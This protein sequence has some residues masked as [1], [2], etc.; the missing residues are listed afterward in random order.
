[1]TVPGVDG[2]KMSKSYN[3]Y[4][5]IFQTDKKLRKNVMKIVTD[6]TPME[7]P[8]DPDNCNVFKLYSLLGTKE[9]I[10]AMRKN[11]EGGNYGFGHAKQ[12]LFE[13]ICIKFSDERKRFEEYINNP[14]LIEKLGKGKQKAQSIATNIIS[15]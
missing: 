12:A 5:D 1:M 15:N 4:I 2:Q 13:L 8:K 10:D 11:Y 3:N 9:Q 14:V 6:S 7:D